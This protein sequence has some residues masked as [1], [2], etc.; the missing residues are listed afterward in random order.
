[1]HKLKI[2]NG[3]LVSLKYLIE[4]PGVYLIKNMKNNKKQ[5]GSSQYV[6]S[7]LN[8]HYKKSLIGNAINKHLENAI[9]KDG[10][11]NLNYY[12]LKIIPIHKNIISELLYWEQYF[13]KTKNRRFGYNC[14]DANG[15]N[16]QKMIIPLKIIK[17]IIYLYTIKN[18]SSLF[19][20]KKY[21]L[22]CTKIKS[23]LKENN[24]KLKKISEIQSIKMS[25]KDEQNIIYLYLNKNLTI[26]EIAKKYNFCTITISRLLVKNKINIAHGSTKTI[27]VFSKKDINHMINLYT[28]EKKSIAKIN[29]LFNTS[30]VGKIL[31]KNNIYIRTKIKEH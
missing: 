2:I 28:K 17:N 23:I 27:I 16:R 14:Q 6:L 7:R 21:K 22:S 25:K 9:K 18:K 13:Y 8:D 29:I 26:C 12:I 3:K 31:K 5:I 24:I 1:M 11:I 15:Y 30:L 10:A 20:S 19:L 4:T